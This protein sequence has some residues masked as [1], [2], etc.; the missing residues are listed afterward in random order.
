MLQPANPASQF[1]P[2]G[3]SF[4]RKFS[5]RS[6]ENWLMLESSKWRTLASA[7]RCTRSFSVVTLLCVEPSTAA[8]FYCITVFSEELPHVAKGAVLSPA[9]A[10]CFYPDRAA[11]RHRHHRHL[12]RA[13][14][15]RCPK[16]P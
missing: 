5:D 16:G 2:A 8:V 1:Y 3:K 15:A 9:L 7:D 4:L 14:A 13:V 6:S 11:S 12:D 10:A